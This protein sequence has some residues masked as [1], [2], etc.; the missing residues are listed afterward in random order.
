VNNIRFLERKEID[1]ARWN[2]LINNSFNSLPYALTSYLDSV[3]ENWD[4]LV[5]NN[6]EAVMPLVW[7]RKFGIKCLYQP[8]Y[9]QQ[10]GV[11]SRTK[12]NAS[13]HRLFLKEATN[14]FAYININLNPAA[15]TVDKD[16]GLHSKKNL[17]LQLT[18][19]YDTLQKKYSAN[20]RRNI[21]KANKAQLVFSE[22]CDLKV[23][24]KFYLENINRNKENFKPRHEKIFKKLTRALITGG[25]GA[26]FTAALPNNGLQAAVLLVTHQNRLLAIINT[27]S[28]DGKK[29][30]ASHF[31]FDRIIHRFSN[32]E[33]VL[34]FEGSSIPTIARFYEGFGAYEETFFNYK[35]TLIKNIRQRFA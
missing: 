24:Q 10:L 27:S 5:L 17:L 9:C 7:L 26:I 29:T 33:L 22:Q 11:F 23:F 6:Y 16:F 25:Q 32:S 21:A 20:H 12:I 3:A 35:T 14:R 4:A 13:L 1:D 8:Y 28:L 30:G 15:I 34:D 19:G 2:E 18:A 31:L